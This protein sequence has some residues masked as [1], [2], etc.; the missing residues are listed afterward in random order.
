MNYIIL[1]LEW[2]QC[3]GGKE[4]ENKDIQFEIV[5]IGA[6]KL[7]ENRRY[8][9][10]FHQ[11]ISPTV[12]RNLHRITRDIIKITIEDLDKGL[13]FN[14]AAALFFEWCSQGG[15]YIF[16]TW[17]SMDLTELQRNCSFFKVEHTFDKPLV[18]YDI[19][20]LYSLCYSD[21]KT[22][23]SLETAIDERQIAK[24]VPFHAAVYDAIYTA[25]IFEKMDFESV[26]Q[27]TSVD[28]FRIPESKSEEFNFYYGTYSKYVSRGFADRDAVM[29]DSRVQSMKC[30]VC[31]KNVRKKIRWFSGNQKMYYALGYC[32]Q[33]GYLRGKI[34]IRKSEDNLF[35]A[36]KI[37]KLTDEEGASQIKDRQ[38]STREK[39]R[40][41]RHRESEK[42]RRRQ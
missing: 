17:G 16:G 37:L 1:D 7:D 40:E 30:Y 2:N 13:K 28:T 35:Y 27:F 3:P 31:G 4:K 8:I 14:Q 6:V 26:K 41:R 11:L 5:E 18:Y 19:Q 32:E 9:D 21:G 38:L 25:R 36:I 10:E 20:K 29:K 33:H 15:E 12:Y 23:V 22:R 42:L 34:K 24:D 39:R